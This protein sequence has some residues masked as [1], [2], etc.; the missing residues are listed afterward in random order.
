[1]QKIL[2]VEDEIDLKQAIKTTLEGVGYL[3]FEASNGKEGITVAL[4]EH[5]DLILVDIN[6][7]EL[8]GHQML[9]K[10]RDDKWGKEVK[11]IYLTA[12]SDPENV[13]EAVDKG[14]DQYLVKSNISLEEVVTKVKQVLSG[15]VI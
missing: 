6:M 1:M 10:I 5:P 11:A 8:N 12:Y 15:Y 9:S 14:S 7:P 3:V 2:I 13:V 4:R